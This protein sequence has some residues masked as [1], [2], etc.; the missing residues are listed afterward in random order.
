M[1]GRSGGRNV[2]VP[3]SSSLR[4]RTS[5]ARE[6]KPLGRASVFGGG[7]RPGGPT[8]QAPTARRT[9]RERGAGFGIQGADGPDDAGSFLKG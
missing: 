3:S 1:V 5:D 7:R 6:W 8:T 4:A 9:L 2:E